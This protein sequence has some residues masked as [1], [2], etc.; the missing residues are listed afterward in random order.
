MASKKYS[1]FAQIEKELEILK[2]EREI[3][4]KKAL[5]SIHKTKDSILP[6]KSVFLIES[7]S[8]KIFKGLY[9]KTLKILMTYLLD[10]FINK[11]RSN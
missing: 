11:K 4:Y 8:S 10:R 6:A 5:L 1:S 2:L 3:Y 7:I 9:R